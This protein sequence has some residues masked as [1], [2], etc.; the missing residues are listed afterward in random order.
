M[1]FSFLNFVLS[2]L[3]V[4]SATAFA[5]EIEQFEN[6]TLEGKVAPGLK[7]SATAEFESNYPV[8][9]VLS[10][11]AGGFIP[12]QKEVEATVLQ[13]NDGS[14]KLTL[15]FAG[16]S[17]GFC[18]WQLKKGLNYITL[19]ISTQDDSKKG[20]V[21][22]MNGETNTLNTPIS[23][24]EGLSCETDSSGQFICGPKGNP[25]SALFLDTDEAQLDIQL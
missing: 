15:D 22:I 4:L 5:D 13:D 2:A 16:N 20:Y 21:W 18:D 24:G 8:C 1:K 9:N 3:L 12:R 6:L 11:H 10:L 14:Y 23:K 25:K 19:H 17:G 7:L